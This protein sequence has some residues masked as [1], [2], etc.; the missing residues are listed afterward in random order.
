MNITPE[1]FRMY[2]SLNEQIPWRTIAA[3]PSPIQKIEF[4]NSSLWIKRDDLSSESFSGT[5]IR[6]LEFIIADAEKKGFK[7]IVTIGGIGSNHCVCTAKVCRQ[8]GMDCTLLLFK[9]PINSFVVKNLT[10]MAENGVE[11][12]LID[13][14]SNDQ[15]YFMS[16]QRIVKKRNAFFIPLGGSSPVGTIGIVNA[17]FELKKQIEDG[18][19][20]CP[21]YIYSAHGSGGTLAGLALGVHLAGLSTNVVGVSVGTASDFK[22]NAIDENVIA[23]LM[24]KTQLYLYKFLRDTNFVSTKA[25]SPSVEYKYEG[26]G[27]GHISQGESTN[28]ALMQKESGIKLDPVYTAK[29]C[30][31]VLRAVEK[32]KPDDK[33][34]FWLTGKSIVD[35]DIKIDMASFPVEFQNLFKAELAHGY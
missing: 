23:N 19:I 22:K 28:I 18:V 1:L 12:I 24:L 14:P 3:W 8:L 13:P 29:A 5:K 32:S 16:I 21:N 34:L 20:P 35:T 30:E 26:A 4:A 15:I 27:Y 31:A 17:V 9:Q 33:I 2:P 6:K 11:L 25:K 7:H 10:E